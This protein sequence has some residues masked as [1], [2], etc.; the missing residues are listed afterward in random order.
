MFHLSENGNTVPYCCTMELNQDFLGEAKLQFQNFNSIQNIIFI[1]L[2]RMNIFF[3][4]NGKLLKIN[5]LR[6]S[7]HLDS[8]PSCIIKLL[9]EIALSIARVGLLECCLVEC[10]QSTVPEPKLKP[11]WRSLAIWPLFFIYLVVRM[12][13]RACSGGGTLFQKFLY[14]RNRISGHNT[15]T[16]LFLRIKFVFDDWANHY[17]NILLVWNNS[18]M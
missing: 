12:I 16:I 11:N 5:F 4:F 6:S 1:F 14:R 15:N 2:Y 7:P 13:E 9:S 17:V 8:I 18:P 10:T 3:K